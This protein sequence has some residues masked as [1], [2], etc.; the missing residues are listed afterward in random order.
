MRNIVLNGRA[1]LLSMVFDILEE[2][3]IETDW[4]WNEC[5]KGS[6]DYPYLLILENTMEYHNHPCK[7]GGTKLEKIDEI[8]FYD[9]LFLLTGEKI[10]K[11]IMTY[12][13]Y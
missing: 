10:N 8:N 9:V 12:S 5:K 4:K 1:H 11:E 6:E 7:G 2:R 13:I 3:G